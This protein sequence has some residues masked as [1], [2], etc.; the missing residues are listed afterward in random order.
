M[1]ALLCSGAKKLV[2]LIGFYV[3]GVR[4]EGIFR[5]SDEKFKRNQI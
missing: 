4:L 2:S 1:S 3:L 5:V